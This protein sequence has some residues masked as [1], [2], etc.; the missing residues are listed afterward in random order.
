M[1]EAWWLGPGRCGAG[2]GALVRAAER[3][4]SPLLALRRRRTWWRSCGR[5]PRCAA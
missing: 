2:G 1:A 5:C 4:P 3:S